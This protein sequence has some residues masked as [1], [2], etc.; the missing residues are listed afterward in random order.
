MKSKT[1][2][3]IYIRLVSAM[4]GLLVI[5]SAAYSREKVV[6]RSRPFPKAPVEM[7]DLKSRG[8][9]LIFGRAFEGGA[10]WLKDLSFSVRN[11]SRKN[12]VFISLAIDF[13]EIK[14]PSI[15]RHNVFLGRP[16]NTNCCKHLPLLSLKPGEAINVPLSREYEQFGQTV[17][18]YYGADAVS[19]I[20]I[21][22]G[23]VH[24]EDG[25]MWDLG[26]TYRPNTEQVGK[27]VRVD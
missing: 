4:M 20:A 21:V 5:T 27:W 2:F 13:T 15:F 24:F 22:L 19:T 17:E 25:T 11:T 8:Q 7:A 6:E 26:E 23:Q 12:I 9:T 3:A 10:G 1:R 18:K 16:T 14:I